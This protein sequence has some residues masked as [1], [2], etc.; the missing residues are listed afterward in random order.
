MSESRRRI[1]TAAKKLYARHGA[2][3]VSMRRVASALG[4]TATSIYRHYKDKEALV[5]SIAEAGFTVLGQYFRSARA[6][7]G[8]RVLGV[9]KRYLDFALSEPRFYE[10]MFL[11]PRTSVRTF[12]DDF[13][14]HRSA[15]FDIL[16][17]EVER[18]M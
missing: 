12:P 11:R 1:G 13:A 7:H 6:V 15:T 17:A 10:V 5:E 16:R 2:E 9:A 14:G 18:E 3:G 4:V 8:S